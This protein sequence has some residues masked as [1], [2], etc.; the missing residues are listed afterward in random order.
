MQKY[1]FTIDVTKI[2]KT[3]LK[4]RTYQN[5]EGQDVTVK[6]YAFEAILNKEEVIK[7]GDTWELVKRGFITQRGTVLAD[8]KFSKEPTFGDVTEI[9]DKKQVESAPSVQPTGFD[10]DLG[11]ISVDDIPF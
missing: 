11:E 3:K 7:T 6:E 4:E 9:R 1:S 10:G 5:K 8:G 2:D